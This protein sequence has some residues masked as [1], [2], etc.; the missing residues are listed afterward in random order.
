MHGRLLHSGSQSDRFDPHSTRPFLPNLQALIK[1]LLCFQ[2]SPCS[3]EIIQMLFIAITFYVAGGRILV[4]RYGCIETQCIP[5]VTR[6]QP[7]R[8]EGVY[9]A[10]ETLHPEMQRP[11]A[12][13]FKIEELLVREPAEGGGDQQTRHPLR[14]SRHLPTFFP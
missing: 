2:S 6:H 8:G 11:T 1:A 4:K 7:I 10:L 9:D 3:T 5:A 13:R 12:R 14:L